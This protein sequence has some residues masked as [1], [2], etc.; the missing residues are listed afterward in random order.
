MGANA[1]TSVPAFTAGQVL[2]AAQMTQVNTGIPV[3]ADSTARDAA[4]GG[5]GEKT[6]AEGQMAYLE[7]TNATQYYDGS[8]WA[9]VAGGKILQVVSTT[10]SDVWSESVS[11]TGTSS[12][13]TGLTA[14]ITPSDTSSKVLVFLTIQMHVAQWAWPNVFLMRDTTHIGG[15]VASGSMPSMTFGD[16]SGDG[17]GTNYGGVG[18]LTGHYL[19]SP[20]STSALTYGIKFYNAYGLTATLALNECYYYTTANNPRYS[21][22]ITVMEVAA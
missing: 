2:T 20:A 17:P 12:L 9:A 13:V 18:N 21:S 4:F 22:M 11:A 15:G 10:K 3:F 1:Q 14:T 5:T 16:F 7:D 19:D 8:S 6:L